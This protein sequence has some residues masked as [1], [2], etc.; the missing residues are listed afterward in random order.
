MEQ[1][2]F[3]LKNKSS[4]YKDH[5][6]QATKEEE[7]TMIRN[8]YTVLEDFVIENFTAAQSSIHVSNI[9]QRDNG[10]YIAYLHKVSLPKFGFTRNYGTLLW[11]IR[12][13]FTLQQ[14][15]I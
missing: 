2:L 8:V 7:K 1:A 14:R 13:M 4:H 15:L 10:V 3:H 9:I 5:L 12:I 6:N 11:Q